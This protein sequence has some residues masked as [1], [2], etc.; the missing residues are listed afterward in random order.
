[1]SVITANFNIPRMRS[2]LSLKPVIHLH[3][4]RPALASA[5]QMHHARANLA[6][7]LFERA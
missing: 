4:R 5:Q 3:N 6:V 2:S 7:I 1:M